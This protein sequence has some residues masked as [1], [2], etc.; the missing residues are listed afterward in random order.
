M[1]ITV[2]KAKPRDSKDVWKI[3]NNPINRKFFHD[4]EEIK[5][6]DHNKWFKKKYFKEDNLCFVCFSSIE[7]RAIGYC[8]YDLEDNHYLISIAVDPTYQNRGIGRIILDATLD[9]VD[10]DVVA[11]ILKRNTVSRKLFEG[12]SMINSGFKLFKEDKTTYY[13]KLNN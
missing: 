1:V 10:K 12:L 8:R 11:E 6:K 13:F 2:E 5:F 3:R 9:K 7:K 4:K